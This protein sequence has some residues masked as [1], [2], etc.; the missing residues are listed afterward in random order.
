MC[1]DKVCDGEQVTEEGDKVVVTMRSGHSV[2][3]RLVVGADGNA[4]ACRKF[5]QV[6]TPP[7]HSKPP[8]RLPVT[9]H[10]VSDQY[11]MYSLSSTLL[12]VLNASFNVSDKEGSR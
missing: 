7:C 1:A 9:L 5:V 3:A 4:S 8:S 6:R 10:N 11:S 12:A 2:R